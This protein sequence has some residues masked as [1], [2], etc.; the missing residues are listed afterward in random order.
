VNRLDPGGKFWDCLKSQNETDRDNTQAA[1][2]N[3]DAPDDYANANPVT[4]DPAANTNRQHCVNDLT[5]KDY[6]LLARIGA[7]RGKRFRHHLLGIAI[8][9]TV[10]GG[11][12]AGDKLSAPLISRDGVLGFRQSA[13]LV[14]Q[15]PVVVQSKTGGATIT[16]TIHGSQRHAG[17]TT[18][19]GYV[20]SQQGV[21]NVM[22]QGRVMPQADGATVHYLQT[23]GRYDIVVYG[24]NGMI[25]TFE[26]M[27]QRRLDGLARRYGW[28]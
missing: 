27:L 17:T 15:Q 16:T 19:R 23:N 9:G 3:F 18:T 22:S 12:G 14:T 26:G 2:N 10:A 1:Q 4:N 6:D 24:R 8:E 25:T 13:A 7:T 5:G 11:V 20:L 28:Q 21:I